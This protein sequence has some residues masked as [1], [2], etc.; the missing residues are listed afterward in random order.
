MSRTVLTV[1]VDAD[2]ATL[3]SFPDGSRSELVD[4]ASTGMAAVVQFLEEVLRHDKLPAE[5]IDR[6]CNGL[7]DLAR[8]KFV[9]GGRIVDG[10]IQTRGKR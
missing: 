8:E 10:A 2:G 6:M 7:M 4:A 9:K 5:M 1:S 3:V